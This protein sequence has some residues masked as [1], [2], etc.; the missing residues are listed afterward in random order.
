M[1]REESGAEGHAWEVK[2]GR[3]LRVKFRTSSCAFGIRQ[4]D[5]S[6]LRSTEDAFYGFTLRLPP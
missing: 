2:V 1:E 3:P 5:K 6:E 4:A